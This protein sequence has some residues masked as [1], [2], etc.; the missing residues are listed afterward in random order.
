[1][2]KG[3]QLISALSAEMV[4][5]RSDY[6]EEKTQADSW[7]Q[8]AKRL[9]RKNEIL[10]QEKDDFQKQITALESRQ[11]DYSVNIKNVLNVIQVPV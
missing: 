2:H 1:M 4:I 9:E 6:S 10:I 11:R 5:V 8:Q 7:Q 3:E